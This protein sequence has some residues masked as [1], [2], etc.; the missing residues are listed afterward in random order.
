MKKRTGAWLTVYALEQLP[1]THTFGIPGV[2]NTELYDQL[3][4]SKKIEPVLVTHEM[5]GAFM[6][7]AVSRT[8]ENI[9]TLVVVPAAGLTHAMSGIGEAFL[10]GTPMLVISGGVRRD[11]DFSYQLH[12]MDQQELMQAY[13]QV[14]LD[15]QK[16]DELHDEI[17]ELQRG[18]L[19]NYRE[20]QVE[21]RG[22]VGQQRFPQLK[23]RIDNVLKQ[24]AKPK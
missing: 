3:N 4:K 11:V 21:I 9:G 6:A 12:E 8:S 5:G 17:I 15:E 24:K 20:L 14:A 13:S 19:L 16:I 22:A 7:D 2:H 18:L 23:Q 10:D 1:I